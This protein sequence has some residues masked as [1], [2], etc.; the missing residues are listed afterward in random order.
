MGKT[1]LLVRF[2]D[3]AFLAGTF[4]STVGIDFRVRAEADVLSA[5]LTQ[6]C[7]GPLPPA[8]GVL[9]T[10][11]GHPQAHGGGSSCLHH[12]AL[13]L[14]VVEVEC[15]EGGPCPWARRL[16]GS[17]ATWLFPLPEPPP[18]LPPTGGLCPWVSGLPTLR[19]P[20]SLWGRQGMMRAIAL[21]LWGSS[22]SP[23]LYPPSLN[24]EC[25][26]KV[27]VCSRQI[28]NLHF[29]HPLIRPSWRE[30]GREAHPRNG[31]GAP[32]RLGAIYPAWGPRSSQVF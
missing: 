22:M 24:S 27:L 3:G 9:T 10:P 7:P 6:L 1:C 19:H 2:K 31:K 28:P 17:A 16:T 8:H 26:A 32:T 12:L 30:A 23:H 25:L 15:L 29:S 21:G 5:E 20:N 18:I 11:L 13:G 14:R 4:I